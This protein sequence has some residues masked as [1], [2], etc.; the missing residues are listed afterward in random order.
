L[1]GNVGGDVATDR[2]TEVFC[3]VWVEFAAIV[4]V[5]DVDLGA[6]EETVDLDVEWGFDEL[7]GVRDGGWEDDGNGKIKKSWFTRQFDRARR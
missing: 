4:A 3:S 5:W 7:E 1:T 6:V 2:V